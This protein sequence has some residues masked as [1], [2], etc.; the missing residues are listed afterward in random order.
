MDQKRIEAYFEAHQQEML[1]DICRLVRIRSVREPAEPGKPFGHGPWLALEEA[2]KLLEEKGFAVR[3]FDHY[4]MDADLPG[5][6]G[7]EPMLGILAHLDVVEEGRG[8]TMNPYEPVIKDGCIYGRGTADDKGP[9]IAGLYAMMAAREIE[10]ELT[11]G[12]RLILGSAEETGSQDLDYYLAREKA[13]EWCFSPD[14]DFP[15]INIEKGRYAPA[16]SAKWEAQTQLPR[17]KYAKGG[18]TVNIVPQ[19][20][21]ALVEGVAEAIM[22]SDATKVY[23]MNIMTQQGERKNTPPKTMCRSSSAM[24]GVRFLTTAS[25]TP[26]RFPKPCARP[27]EP[28]TRTSSLP[29]KGSWRS[30]ACGPSGPNCWP[31]VP[32]PATIR[33][34]WPRR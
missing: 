17:V 4:V 12:V 5:K 18:A 23:V 21:E 26:S 29:G 20:A 22:Q 15:V 1:E 8:W 7:K 11:R 34:V 6:D 30:W 31:R 24:Q 19:N 28:R 14:A 13:P 2:R 16:F 9:A 32:W 10:P 27:T 33:S 25:S 3:N